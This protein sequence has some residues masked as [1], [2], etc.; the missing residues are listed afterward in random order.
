MHKVVIII[1]T[2]LCTWRFKINDSDEV[3]FLLNQGADTAI[4]FGDQSV[5]HSTSHTGATGKQTASTVMPPFS[6]QL[7][8]DKNLKL[9]HN[10]FKQS[11]QKFYANK[12]VS[13]I[14][15]L[16]ITPPY[17]TPYVLAQFA[18]KAYADN[19]HEDSEHP[20]GW[21]LLTTA[22]NRNGYFGT[23][24]WHPKHQQVVIAHRGTDTK[25]F[26]AFLVDF[27][28]DFK[29]VVFNKYVDQMSSA[30]TFANKVVAALQKIEQEM[31]VSFELFF[32]GHSLGGWLAQI[33]TFTTEYLEA[34]GDT[35]LM[36][37]KTQQGEQH[38]S[39]T[40]QDS[41]D[42][43]DEFF[44]QDTEFT[45]KYVK[46]NAGTYPKKTKTEQGEQ[47]ACSTIQGSHDVTYSYHAHTVV[48]ES[49][50]CETMLSQMKR[51][52]DV[53]LLGSCIDLRHLDITSYLSA[54]NLFNTLNTHL[55]TVYRIFTNL[56]DMDL[57]ETHTPLYN[58][59]THIMDKIVQAFDPETGQ[60][61]INDE[62]EPKIQ[63]V[64]DW[65]LSEGL[66]Y[67]AELNEFFKW[68]E[69]LNNYHPEVKDIS[70]TQV[71]EGFHPLRYQTKAY[72]DCTKCLS[73]FTQDE[74]EFLELYRSL[75]HVPIV[76][77]TEDLFSVMNNAEAT[78]EAKQKLQNFELGDE[79][80]RCP[81]ASTLHAL[82]P[83]VKRLVRLFPH[84]KE[85]IKAT[86]SSPQLISRVYQHETQRYVENIHQSTLNFNPGAL[87]L[88][89][90][91]TSDKQI[92]LLR[93]TD[94]DAWT[95][96]REVYWVLQKTSRTPNYSSEGHY[97]IL[98][99][100]HL[101]TVNRLIK[102]NALLIPMEIP[103][104]LMIACGTNQTIN[105]ELKNMFQG[106]FS[107]LKQ[108]N[109]IKV[110][111]IS[112][113]NDVTAAHIQKI[114]TETLGLRF[115]TTDKQLTWSDL[116]ASSQTQI[117]EET[118]IFQGMQVALNKLTSVES[119]TDS[120]PLS[121]LIQEKKIRI[122]EEPVLSASSGYNETYY[123]DRIFD[124]NIV[125]RQDITSDKRQ[126]EF[127]DLLASTEEEFKQ[128]CQQNPTS[129]VH[130]L[131]EN[132]SGELIWQ[133][134]QGNL[135]TLREYIDAQKPLSYASSDLENMLQRAKHQRIMLIAERA[136]MGKTTVLTHLS[137]RIK[138][139]LP[140]HWLVRI[141]LNDYTE[142]LKDQKR[143]E[144]DKAWVLEF[145]SNE[146]L[147]LKSHLEKELFKNTFEGKGVNKLVVMFDGFDEIS[148]NYKET[149][150]EMMQ[151][152]K[153]TSLEQ[154]WVTTRPHL[155][156]ELEDNL[157]QLSYTLQ[158]FSEFEQ[159]QFLEKFW[160]ENL[161]LVVTDQYRLQIY[162]KT[163]IR[164]LAQSISDKD[165][166]FTGIPLQTHMLAEGFEKQF[167]LFYLSEKSDPELPEK[168][169]LLGLYRRFID[170]KY[171]ILYG[172]KAA[173]TAG[174]IVAEEAREFHLKFM[175]DQHQRLA[176]QALF[177][178]DQLTFLQI[179]DESTLTDEQMAMFGIAQ[180]NID[181]KPHFIHR[182]FAEI[183]VAE[184][185][186]KQLKKKTRPNKQVQELLL[187]EV[188]LK[189]DYHVIRAFLD[190]LL[191]NSMPSAE[192]LKDYGKK[193]DEQWNEGEAQR[194][195][196][197][198][199]AA[200][201][202]AAAE[203]NV[204][205]IGFIVDSL[206][207]ADRFNTVTQMMSATDDKG[208]NIWYVAGD[209]RSLQALNKIGE[210]VKEL[211]TSSLLQSQNQHK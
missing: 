87:G 93:I 91:L 163:L 121:E 183:Y 117:L 60:V 6:G 37:L 125:I 28:A 112:H 119:M 49:P 160:T 19:Q 11:I 1:V 148:P 142:L 108:R 66:Y 193:F 31:M 209:N 47:N 201:F 210:W 62:G 106:L 69:H 52:F 127:T 155:K 63:E 30:S 32:T 10:D 100:E 178:E 207:S 156:E 128:L 48:F 133:Q 149:V 113:S 126:K 170:R 20:A 152:L 41:H 176:L 116:T 77:K 202:Q 159:V 165:R 172:D 51:T 82:I 107:I 114:A 198:V 122:G 99:L 61:L 29:G 174:K 95:G 158:P 88:R 145:V 92:W 184:F 153:Q 50:G 134:S 186:I 84:I 74:R 23:A 38:P 131:V 42:A 12:Q 188:L 8:V 109:T 200:L 71:P 68:A 67:G 203:D 136:G 168:L 118:V 40:V 39:S 166:E 43:Q 150:I 137:K 2:L 182:T 57:L 211:T 147:K 179:D 83:Y 15:Q 141:D 132:K 24:Y 140:T 89:K 195:Q 123:I 105:D 146:V 143:K 80:V 16:K 4:K 3:N 167:R 78:N 197:G 59:A 26:S 33:T 94:G 135:K 27:S 111:L 190:G 104:L 205:I 58:L 65:P 208:R 75:G 189:P 129:N 110:I 169:D 196:T 154:L 7:R 96:L 45:F 115:N 64:V 53:R 73:I 46:D 180:R 44:T 191:G 13:A 162:A 90:F 81:D 76:L 124:H 17:P 151:I 101:L 70:Y 85:H 120:I 175:Q 98:E 177:T 54:P 103:H 34:K 5:F 181:G 199:F 206:K 204:N 185:L 173:P 25:N 171:D 157:Q 55:G 192:V 138:Q 144:I 86:L 36:K 18:S 22:S 35:F 14:V 79:S 164:K 139:I 130:W 102:L 194:P 9:S 97:T 161:N 187:N 21:Q 56:S 72:D